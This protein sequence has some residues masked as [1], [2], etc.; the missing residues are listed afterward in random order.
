MEK[1]KI[2]GSEALLKAL[3]AE[4]VDTIF[5]YPGG[6]AIPIYDS[7]Y[8]YRDQL[9]HVL[10]RHEQGA[11][12]AAQGYARV[13]GKV[14]V[15]LVTSGP[16]ATNT[17]TGIADALMD[18]TPM[19][20]IAGQ[21]PSPLLGTDA[22]QEV[23]VIG[24]TQPITKWAYQIRKP[25]E[26]A[27][28]VSRAFYIASTGRPGPVVLD[29]AK[30]AQVGLVEYEYKKVD[31]VRSYQPE[32]DINKDRIK[33]A[34]D[35]INEAK[36]PFCLVGQGVLLGG[37][38]EELKAF[39][40][41]NDIPAGSTV[42]GLSA[43][44]TD[45]PLNK[46]ML[47]MHGNVGPNRKTNECDVLIAIGMRFDDRVTGDLKTYAKQAK[48]IHLDI[49]N[50]EIGKNVAVDVKVLGNAKHT[51]PMITALLEERKRPE[52]NAEFDRDEKEEYDK[53]IEKELYP[54]EGQLKMGEVV[55]KVSEATGND[56]VLVTDV[57][58]NQMMG[59]RYFKY[60]QTRSVVTSGGLGAMGFGLPA[61]M[62]AK[63]GAPDRT[64]CFFTGDGGMQMT[65]QELGTI[66]QE[67]LNV[68]IIIL[69][70]NFL[71]MV[72]QW[73]EL[74]F[75]ERYSNTIMENPDFVAIAKAYGIAGRAVEKREELDDAIAEMLNHDG[76]YVLVANVETCGM[77]YPMVPAGGSVTNMIMGDE[78]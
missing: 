47:G 72:R 36:K 33:A 54:T 31:Y 34:A 48:I 46:G 23:D 77:V 42:L 1:Q 76:A 78:K 25:E 62:G 3:I 65:I 29:L 67:K 41:K 70:N 69:N 18:S 26:I 73:Q 58:Q 9:R 16:G 35:L 32:P 21:V 14:G 66:M 40:Q 19:V 75:H 13:S 7:L 61:A 57:G 37:A 22:F 38:E 10:V 8:D 12:H 5:G 6:Q 55:R 20:V 44:P 24:I 56:A 52:W 60:K 27:W 45:F 17:I 68:K 64:V 43:L 59:V 28:A 63:F 39:L 53:V 50:S 15:T 2:T 49:D 30:D 11:T 74:F 51:I 4:G 71:G